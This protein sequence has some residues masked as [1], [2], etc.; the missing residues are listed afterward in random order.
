VQSVEHGVSRQA[1]VW[2]TSRYGP[3]LTALGVIAA[4]GPP[5]AEAVGGELL[6]AALFTVLMLSCARAVSH[7]PAT[8]RRMLA[9]AL[10]VIVADASLALDPA[11]PLVL[12]A[13]G[14]RAAFLAF[15]TIAILT[16]VVRTERVTHD[17]ILG[18]I[19]VY[20]LIGLFFQSV[21]GIVEVIHPGSFRSG[22]VA[23]SELPGANGARGRYPVLVYYSFVTLSTVGFGDII[24]TGSLPQALSATEAVVGQLYLAIL[25]ASLVG[26]RLAAGASTTG[27]E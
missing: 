17:T 24:P 26:M 3:L 23:V 12:A 5:L 10:V 14:L 21:F 25:V 19:C 27:K 4:F 15:V 6:I 13:S 2:A 7:A 1:R 9:L 8:R 11:R 18:G 20:L 16:H 22:G